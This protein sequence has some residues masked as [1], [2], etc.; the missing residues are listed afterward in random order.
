MWF[1]V[2]RPI[3]KLHLRRGLRV[4]SWAV[5][6]VADR[7]SGTDLA[8]NESR[9]K[10]LLRELAEG[11]SPRDFEGRHVHLCA[12]HPQVNCNESHRLWKVQRW[13]NAA[14]RALCLW[15]WLHGTLVVA[16]EPS[17]VYTLLYACFSIYPIFLNDCFLLQ[18]YAD[19][20]VISFT[21][22]NCYWCCWANCWY[23]S[24]C[25]C[26]T[27]KRT[28]WFAQRVLSCCVPLTSRSMPAVTWQRA[29]A[30]TKLCGWPKFV[31]TKMISLIL[32]SNGPIICA[33][34]KYA[35]VLF[36][37]RQIVKHDTNERDVLF[38]SGEQEVDCASCASLSRSVRACRQNAARVSISLVWLL[39]ATL[40]MFSAQRFCCHLVPV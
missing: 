40:C 11:L 5:P 2:W 8:G 13:R 34:T 36:A 37:N 7:S 12:K 17:A 35:L 30:G 1:S 32:W 29:T 26:E 10:V 3:A 22:L 25:K 27:F 21:S 33:P 18:V 15:L 9:R 38:V 28:S 4:C 31:L 23:I 24:S 16:S 19:C 39:T 6:C 14:Y 20:V